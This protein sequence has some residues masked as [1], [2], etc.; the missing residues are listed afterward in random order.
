MITMAGTPRSPSGWSGTIHAFLALAKAGWLTAM[1]E[2]YRR[3]MDNP[4]GREQ[5]LVWELEFELLNKELK[6][7]VQIRPDFGDCTLIFDYESPR[8]RGWHP[9]LIILAVPVFVL[10]FRNDGQVLQAHA[11]Q[12]EAFAEDLHR[13][14]RE[15]PKPAIVPVLVHTRAKDLIVRDGDTIIISP[16][17]IADFLTVESELETGTL[18]DAAAWIAAGY[19]LTAPR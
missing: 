12:L 11:D 1:Q 19:E 16:N 14:H 4:A 3:I 15:S 17:R 10:V 2:H 18:I 9:D 6:Q 13:Y 5:V 8:R 7:L